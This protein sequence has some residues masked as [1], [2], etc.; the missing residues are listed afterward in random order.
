MFTGL[1][2]KIGVLESITRSAGETRIMISHS[3]WDRPLELGESVAVQGVCLTVIE[4]GPSGFTCNLLQ[5]T[6]ER[7]SL[8]KTR[9]GC[10]V[11]LERALRT[12]DALGGHLVA[13]HVDGMGRVAAVDRSGADRILRVECDESVARGIV[14]KGSVTCDGVSLTVARCSP[15][16]FEVNLIPFTWDNTSLSRLKAGDSINIEVDLIG[17]YVERYVHGGSAGGSVTLEQLKDAGFA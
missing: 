12:G 17:K 2:Q 4:A 10:R 14:F 11:N 8:G 13:G 16:G 1:I 15:T 7:T 9:S 3:A 5:E 6:L